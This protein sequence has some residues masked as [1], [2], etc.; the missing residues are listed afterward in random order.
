MAN[1]TWPDLGLLVLRLSIGLSMILFHG[2]GKI[3]GGPE[4]WR[5]IGGAMEN[6]GID[7]LPMFWGFMAGFTEF[8]GSVL[9]ILGLFFRP[10]AALLARWSGRA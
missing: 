7:F 5:R 3:S 6:F 10:A 8:F 2:W 1:R 9:I 4:R